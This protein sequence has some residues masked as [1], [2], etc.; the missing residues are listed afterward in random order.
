[1]LPAKGSQGQDG[2]HEGHS[3][4]GGA[5]AHQRG[6]PSHSAVSVNPMQQTERGGQGGPQ[7]GKRQKALSPMKGGN[8]QNLMSQKDEGGR[9]RGKR[10]E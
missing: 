2:D 10:N 9:G 6:N 4:P 8:N 1:M 7:R 3:R 5:G